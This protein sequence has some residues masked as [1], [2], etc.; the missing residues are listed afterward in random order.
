MSHAAFMPDVGENGIACAWI[1]RVRM[2]DS[3]RILVVVD[4]AL[5]RA[6]LVHLLES[7]LDL[8]VVG[9]CGS[10]A[11]ARDIL[12]CT[13]VDMVLLDYDFGEESGAALLGELQ[14]DPDRIK[15]LVVTEGKSDAETV[16]ILKAGAAGVLYK[17]RDD[18]AQLLEAIR[19]ISKG[20]LWLDSNAIRSLIASAKERVPEER[21]RSSLSLRQQQVLSGVLDG[22]SNKAI[23]W[24]LQ[25][26]TSTTKAVLRELFER[27]GVQRRSQLVRAALQEHAADWF[28]LL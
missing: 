18:P 26:S 10:I 4:H 19:K 28:P 9:H 12:R 21:R 24:R 17:H 15:V 11:D 13:A 25:V 7:E 8:K 16:D 23:A 27:A 6:S 3:T 14:Q 22:L 1:E 20:Q 2:N 5:F